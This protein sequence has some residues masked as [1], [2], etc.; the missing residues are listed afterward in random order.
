MADI[1]DI[2]IKDEYELDID[3]EIRKKLTLLLYNNNYYKLNNTTA[4]E[5]ARLYMNKIKLGITYNDEVETI[6]TMLEAYIK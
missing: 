5:I 2:I 3:F 6:L 1:H 4:V